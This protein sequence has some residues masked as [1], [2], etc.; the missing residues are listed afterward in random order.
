[1]FPR[2]VVFIADPWFGDSHTKGT[3]ARLCLPRHSLIISELI[4]PIVV[5]ASA[6]AYLFVRVCV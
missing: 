6:V 5:P 4:F 1:M 2:L 3:K